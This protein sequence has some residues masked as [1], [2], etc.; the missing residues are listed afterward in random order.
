[1]KLSQKIFIVI[2]VTSVVLMSQVRTPQH[3]TR[4]M[5]HQTVF[6]TGE[7][8]RAYDRGD[9]G[10]IEGHSSMEWPPNSSATIDGF[11]HRGSHN[12]L[13]GGLYISGFKNGTYLLAACGA[14]TTAG[15]G[16]SVPVA[17]VYV[18]PGTITR[19]ENYP[20]LAN[21]DLNP[22]YN[23]NEAEEIIVAHW[24]TIGLKVAVTRTSRAWSFPGYNSFII[25]EY[26]LVN[27]D[28]VDY[29]D[30]FVGWGY[31]FTPSMFGLE[32]KYNRWGEGDVRSKDMYA[33]YDLKRF[34]S[35]NHDRTGSIDSTFFDLWSQP[36]DRGGL[37][38]PQAVG[39]FPLHYEYQN[40]A[41][42]GQTNYPKTSDSNYVWDA[43]GKMKQ[44]YT[45]RY[46]NANIEIG[47]IQTWLDIN[48]RKTAPF[49]GA[50]DSIAFSTFADAASWA[51]WK[52]R[53]KPT[54][55][56]AYSQPASRGYVFG[57]Y[58]M[59]KGE[60][61]HFTLAEVVGYGAGIESDNIYKD[62]GGSRGTVDS[63]RFNP[64]P[65]WYKEFNYPNA[66]VTS[67][68]V[69]SN[70]LQTH[71]L[72]WYVTPGVVSIRDVADRAIQMYTGN[73]LIKWDSL[74][75]EPKDTPP[76]GV[77]NT[78]PIP[79]PAPSF[80]IENT[81]AAVNR[82]L[83]G[84]QVESFS[85]ARLKAPFSH[86]LAYR[87]TS[88]LGPW[89]LIDSIGKLDARYWRDSTYLLYDKESNLG[90]DAYY[91]I[92]S[93]DTLGKRSGISNFTRHNTQSPAAL[94]LEKVWVTPNPLIVTRGGRGSSINGD[95]ADKIG[96]MGLT[97]K[98]TIR[99]F[100][101]S[102]Q[103]L[104]TIEH[105]TPPTAGYEQEWFQ[106]TRNNQLMASGI[107]FFT[108]DDAAT[109]KRATGKF[110]VIR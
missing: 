36:G 49:N 68:I 45:N 44:P 57:P 71:E 101:Y 10:M 23:P 59:P 108:V 32:R 103:L 9:N 42:K 97:K 109:G 92:Y 46:E 100:S 82:L 63:A 54:A 20:V 3:H 52:G 26:D 27:I 73:P 107:Y 5:L 96:F 28:T 62:F 15:N 13:G 77:Y 29:T 94:S 61:L 86:Y 105:D 84:R 99:I 91:I 102:G 93:V 18:N 53:T 90:E 38:S 24:T 21:G 55:T 60:H 50:T 43:N 66:S 12:S 4:G 47:K 67:N 83:W 22:A 1:M 74:Q 58:K 35:Y 95:F 16:Q 6:N 78:I 81:G 85:S 64:V 110:V 8:G 80:T 33:R 70:Y 14:V 76:T 106:I 87:S 51:Y 69:G 25:Y 41:Q 30:A 98:C 11:N 7:L 34:M 48:S 89:M 72:P 79:V 75:F 2:I 56:L 19:T 37:N 88:A 65:S 17:G 39:I 104:Q 40:L 31:G